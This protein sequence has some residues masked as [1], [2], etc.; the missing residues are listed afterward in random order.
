MFMRK[1]ISSVS[2]LPLIFALAIATISFCSYP[3]KAAAP[4]ASLKYP[5]ALQCSAD[6]AGQALKVVRS[7]RTVVTAYSST[8]DQTDSTPCI[9]ANGYDLCEANE[10][11]VVAANFLRFGTKVRLPEYSGDHIY[12][13]QD[14]M[15]PRFAR[16]MDLWMHTREDAK[17][18][19]LR[20]LTVEVIE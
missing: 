16:R 2:G 4:Q 8:A 3:T 14:R 7:I 5:E 11:N 17:Q 6:D 9:T 18:F 10:E 12:T 19:G 15:N 20:T 13:V 1:I